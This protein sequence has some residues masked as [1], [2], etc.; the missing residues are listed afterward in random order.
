MQDRVLPIR[1]PTDTY[2]SRYENGGSEPTVK[3]GRRY[4][5]GC[6]QRILVVLKSILYIGSPQLSRTLCSFDN[7]RCEH[8]GAC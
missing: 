4:A 8:P 7:L 5:I 1:R 6:K 2:L 3:G